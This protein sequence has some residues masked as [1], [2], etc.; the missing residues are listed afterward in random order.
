VEGRLTEL[1]LSLVSPPARGRS[2]GTFDV[3]A[4]NEV[5]VEL[6]AGEGLNLGP[7]RLRSS[8]GTI[9]V[10]GE[11]RRDVLRA[12]ARGRLE[13]AGL[14]PFMRPWLD[15]IGG[16][17]DVDLSA[18]S[19]STFKDVTLNGSATITE[20]LT[21]KLAG[22]GLEASLPSGTLRVSKNVVDTQ[23]LPVIIRGQAFPVAAVRKIDA[24]A[25]VT[26]RFDAAS[27]QGKLSARIALDNLSVDVPLVGRKPIQSAGGFVDIVGEAATGKL[28]ITRVDIPVTAEAEHLA[29]SAGALVDRATV[30]L[31]VRGSARQLAVSGDIDVAK[32]R[33]NTD[34]LKKPSRG[35]GGSAGKSKGG[36]TDRPE[37][38][39]MAL[40]IRV[41]SKG[42]AI[43][44]DV[45][46]LPDLDL[47]VDMHV[48][49]T[50]KKPSISGTQKGH[51]VWTSFVL[52]L[53][54]LFT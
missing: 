7:T 17:L 48:G 11:S 54:K 43:H 4:E 15:R 33:L 10:A 31:R 40:D 49:G 13:L 53:A 39:S 12:T 1:A 21:A 45:D 36:L 38:A 41:R 18:A 28:D 2:A 20:P 29:P 16:S 44:V 34:A 5:V 27:A 50:V 32:A 35:G 22:Q 46:N 9:E 19:H 47:D 6:R 37:I 52:T 25:R 51:N 3:R 42:G 23:A 8:F 14:G 30:A 26:G 24:K